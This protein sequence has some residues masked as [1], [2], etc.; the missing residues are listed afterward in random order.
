MQ[1]TN[2]KN[3]KLFI[4]PFFHLFGAFFTEIIGHFKE[5]RII[6]LENIRYRYFRLSSGAIP[7]FAFLSIFQLNNN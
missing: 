4:S 1:E 5:F 3:C 2:V 7:T 6:K